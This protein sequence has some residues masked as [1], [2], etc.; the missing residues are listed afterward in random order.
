MIALIMASLG[1][2]ILRIVPKKY[3]T[4]PLPQSWMKRLKDLSASRNPFAPFL[5]GALTFFLPCGF[6]QSM[7][8]L[9]LG[10][11]SFLMGGLIMLTFALGTL[12]S[13]LG[14]SL[15]SAFATG[16]AA[17]IFTLSSGC[18]V[19]LLG[20]LNLQSGFVL[21][22]ID[23]GDLLA[24]AFAVNRNIQLSPDV[25]INEKGQQIISLNVTD[26]GYTPNS[27][28]IEPN[29]ETWIYATAPNGLSGCATTMTA[30]A[31]G[32]STFIHQGTNWLG[33]IKNPT[34]DFLV[35]CSMGM[36]RTNIHVKRSS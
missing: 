4:I 11:G 5:L 25:S 18:A 29:H 12:P 22:G 21:M 20:V 32:I 9:A 31:Y 10:S 17:R 19:L 6:T 7:Q 2:R 28:T 23:P 24:R 35:T 3:C 30:P 8:L 27:V 33:P 36:M 13:L 34:S 15:A 14:I 26:F 16:R 1:L